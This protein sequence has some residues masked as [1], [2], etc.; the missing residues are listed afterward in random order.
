M[1]VNY[2]QWK[3][4]RREL[5]LRRGSVHGQ[6]DPVGMGDCHC[7]SCR[8]WSAGAVNAFILWK[9]ETV[10]ITR[11]A[12]NIG[13]YNKTPNSFRKWCKTC[14]GHIFTEHP[15]MGLTDVVC[16]SHSGLSVQRRRPSATHPSCAA[17]SPDNGHAKCLPSSFRHADARAAH[18]RASSPNKALQPTGQS[19]LSR[20]APELHLS[21]QQA[22]ETISYGHPRR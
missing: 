4:L 11:G 18:F 22:S 5:L 12:E 13:A 15:S 17:S 1:E 16:G 6:R 10:Q 14:E 21:G 7:E 2:E 3:S 9:P 20:P 19:Q 8:R